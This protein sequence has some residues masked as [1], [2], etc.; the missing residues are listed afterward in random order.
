M[1]RNRLIAR[2][3]TVG[4]EEPKKSPRR[5]IVLYVVLIA[6]SMLL[7]AASQSGP[8][9]S[10]RNGVKYAF[11][12][13]Q[14]VLAGGARSVGSIFTAFAEVDTLRKENRDLQAQ[15]T[16]AIQQVQQLEVL[17]AEN[18]KLSEA[19]GTR[20]ALDYK[21]AAAF[22]VARSPSQ[23]ERTITLD[24]GMDA[25]IEV[26]DA[27]LAPGG[28]LAGVVTAV[29][30]GS[31]DVRLLS[32]PRSLHIGRA[33]TSRATGEIVGNFS[34]PLRME[35]VAA[36]ETLTVGDTVVTAGTLVKGFKALLPRDLLIGTIVEVTDDATSFEK[37][38]L[39]QPAADLDR[40]EAVLVITSYNAPQ[41]FDP[42]ATPEPENV[43][44]ASPE[45]EPEA[46]RAPGGKKQRTP[47]P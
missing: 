23:L 34:S 44:A 10:L 30:D 1:A 36:T 9:Q 42:E 45:P 37:S 18:A 13:V 26:G 15:L 40:L 39:I 35:K 3:G 46:S 47:K 25:G 22:V 29:Y 24:R 27:V 2:L 4:G 43:P 32:D 6:M 11:D 17:R 28:A 38:A 8:I 12:P 5:R 31:T 33:A 41:I 14:E 7:L 19:L 16:A 21:T 20:K